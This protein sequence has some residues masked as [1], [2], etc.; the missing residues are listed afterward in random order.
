MFSLGRESK[1]AYQGGAKDTVSTTEFH[2]FSVAKPPFFV[3]EDF[4]LKLC[5]LTSEECEAS[6]REA[7]TTEEFPAWE[8]E[9]VGSSVLEFVQEGT[10]GMF[11]P[12]RITPSDWTGTVVSNELAVQGAQCIE[13]QVDVGTKGVIYDVGEYQKIVW[14]FDTKVDQFK[15]STFIDP[16]DIIIKSDID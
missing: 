14:S 10:V 3:V 15:Y 7:F 11:R 13:S 16:T 5:E 8:L 6:N 9:V 2:R 12:C 4:A 1:V